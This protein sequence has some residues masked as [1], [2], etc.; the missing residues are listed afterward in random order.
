MAS[1]LSDRPTQA[2]GVV[3][4]FDNGVFEFLIVT[5]RR[6]PRAW[7]LPK[8]NIEDDETPE[9]AAVREVEEEAG[10]IAQI[11]RPL[12]DLLIDTDDRNQRIRFFLM[13]VLDED[14][15]GEGR[16]VRWVSLEEALDRLTF[17][18]HRRLI[19]EAASQLK[20]PAP[21]S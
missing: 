19:R 4:R 16:K 13:T 18:T 12:K 1:T 6:E 5:A 14:E 20:P 10:V 17:L 21:S 8:G 9:E 15:A 2:G 3:Y 7:V 11:E